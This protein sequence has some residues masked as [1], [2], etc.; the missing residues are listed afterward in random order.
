MRTS[1]WLILPTTRDVKNDAHAEYDVFG[2]KNMK[3]MFVVLENVKARSTFKRLLR[4][5]K[6]FCMLKS[7]CFRKEESASQ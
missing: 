6:T 2:A 1:F 4:R 7:Y 5:S 3:D